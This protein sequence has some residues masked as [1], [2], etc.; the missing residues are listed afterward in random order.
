MLSEDGLNYENQDS[1]YEFLL[2]RDK[3]PERHY[4]QPSLHHLTAS[5]KPRSLSLELQWS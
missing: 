2:H 3:S 4:A 5:D 1:E